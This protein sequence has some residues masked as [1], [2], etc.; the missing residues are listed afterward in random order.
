M[1][2]LIQS[3]QERCL[4]ES[5]EENDLQIKLLQD[6]SIFRKN[7]KLNF[8]EKIKL[9]FK[10][11]SISSCFYIFGNVGVGKTLIMDLF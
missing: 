3:Y 11:S 7:L 10:E 9:L 6:L 1:S 5:L 4:S 2:N 8:L